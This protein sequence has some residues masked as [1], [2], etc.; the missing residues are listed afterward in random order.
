MAITMT[1]VKTHLELKKVA[2]IVIKNTIYLKKIRDINLPCVCID[3][4]Y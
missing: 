4:I 1:K 2:I 3:K